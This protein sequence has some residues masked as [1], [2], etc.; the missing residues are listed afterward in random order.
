MSL[1]NL[2]DINPL[3]TQ[4]W[5]EA[6]EAIIEEEGVERAHFLLEKL[7]D[8]SRRS[9]AH[10][11]YSATTAYI[12]TIPTSEEPKMPADMDLERKIRSIIR[13]NAQ[14]MVQ[15]AS[16]KHLELGGHIASFQS[17]ATLY[18]VAFNHF[19]RAPNEKD[20]GDLIFFQG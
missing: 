1:L 20:G 12:N 7:I 5:M 10:L 6:L 17:S 19:F 4:E 3:E 11:P 15:R 8:K 9:G 14:I 16:N 18:D 2:E 13:W